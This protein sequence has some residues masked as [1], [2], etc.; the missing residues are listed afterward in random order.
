ML[1]LRAIR[2]SWT[3]LD[4]LPFPVMHIGVDFD[5]AAANKAAV[6]SFGPVVGTCHRLSH[7]H[8]S[9]CGLNGE[10]CPKLT[11]EQTGQAVSVLHVHQAGR[12]ISRSRVTA[13][14]IVGGGVLLLQVPLDDVVTV[15]GLTGLLNRAEGEQRARRSAALMVR[16]GFGYAVVMLDLDHFK[17]VNDTFGHPEGDRVLLA[18]AEMLRH[19]V[20]QSDVLVR[21]GGEEFLVML[22]GEG[23]EAAQEFAE[24]ILGETRELQI[25]IEGVPIR[26]TVS[27]GLRVVSSTELATLSFDQAVT[28]ADQ[29]MYEA[30]RRG[31]DQLVIHELKE[32][33]PGAEEFSAAHAPSVSSRRVPPRPGRS[34]GRCSG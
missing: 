6:E 25:N 2:E 23:E 28:D 16:L 29:A 12:G 26:M 9:P 15:D 7:G 8:D 33:A 18:F 10:S 5:V 20:R 11:A 13:V 22:P 14:P 17:A 21:W 27:A 4:A 24:R 19:T 1:T 30:K 3:L 31:R 32:F 34:G